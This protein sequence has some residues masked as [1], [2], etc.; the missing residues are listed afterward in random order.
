MWH[1]CGREQSLH[2][3]SRGYGIVHDLM[4]KHLE[5]LQNYACWQWLLNSIALFHLYPKFWSIFNPFLYLYAISLLAWQ[6]TFEL[7]NFQA[8]GVC[9]FVSSSRIVSQWH[10]WSHLWRVCNSHSISLPEIHSFLITACWLFNTRLMMLTSSPIY[11]PVARISRRGVTWMWKV[12]VCMHNHV[13]NTR[14]V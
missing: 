6:W 4:Y 3:S 2:I 14:G 9:W 13:P 1:W 8:I 10:L 12:Y 7:L 11:R 5:K